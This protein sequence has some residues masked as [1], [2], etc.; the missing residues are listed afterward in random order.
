MGLFYYSS[1]NGADCTISARNPTA[2]SAMKGSLHKTE[3]SYAKEILRPKEGVGL[4]YAPTGQKQGALRSNIAYLYRR[5]PDGLGSHRT[6][7]LFPN[8]ATRLPVSH[9]CSSEQD[10][11]RVKGRLRSMLG[12]KTFYNARR[13]IIGIELAQ[14]IHKRQFAIPIPWQSNPVVIWRHVMAA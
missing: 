9:Q 2:A 8:G 13:V 7:R 11:R 10:H 14:K 4:K 5:G 1:A 12:F 3:K 6:P